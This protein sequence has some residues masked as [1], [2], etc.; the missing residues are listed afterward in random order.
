M[1]NKKEGN[2]IYQAFCRGDEYMSKNRVYTDAKRAVR[3]YEGEQWFYEGQSDW[4]RL[5]FYNFI[6]PIVDYK[7]AMVAKNTVALNYLPLNLAAEPLEQEQLLTWCRE[8]NQYAADKWEELKLDTVLWDLIK[9][10]AVLGDAYLFFGTAELTPQIIDNFNLFLADEQEPELQEQPYIVIRERV[11]VSD[12]KKAAKAA[13]L[14]DA[15]IAL[16]AADKPENQV[17]NEDNEVKSDDGKVTSYLYISRNEKHEVSFA[18]ATSTVVYQPETAIP[19]LYRYPVAGFVWNRRY[20]SARGRGEVLPLIP[21]QISTNRLLVRREVNN[22]QSGYPRPV[23]HEEYIKNPENLD[24]VGA[25]IIVRGGQQVEDVARAFAYIQP[26][27]MNGEGTALQNEI[28][29]MTRNLANASDSAT[30]NVDPEKTS[31]K[32]I[33]LV[34]DQNAVMLTEQ[35]ASFKQ[36]CEDIALIW[37]DMWQAYETEGLALAYFVGDVRAEGFLSADELKMLK[38]RIRIDVSNNNPWSVYANDQEALNLFSNGYI[39]FSEYV[40]L[41][42]DQN[43]MKGKLQKIAEA[44][45]EQERLSAQSAPAESVAQA[46]PVDGQALGGMDYALPELQA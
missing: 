26:A 31:G 6:Q 46:L 23:I 5:P 3:F 7:V 38:V 27:A 11:F 17:N 44:R 4:R 9:K 14:S 20:N 36:L 40:E 12:V 10:A 45:E 39:S 19:G 15:E 33:S 16:I 25:K 41:L 32:A 24:K 42:S 30:G 43:H 18:R 35:N 1:R 37:F 8:L 29:E 21:N 13:G 34:I 22:K 2:Y 28:I